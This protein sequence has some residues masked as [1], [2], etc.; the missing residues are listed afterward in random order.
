MARPA[1]KLANAL[2]A[3]ERLQTNGLVAIRSV[4]LSRLDRERLVEAGFLK[5]VMRGWYIPARPDEP[6]GESTAWFASFWEFVTAYLTERL[7]SDWILA[8]DQSLLL[9]SG[10]RTVPQQLLVRAPGGRNKPTELIHGTSLIDTRL[11][12]PA[13]RDRTVTADGVRIYRAEAAL[14]A[15]SPQF[16]LNYPTDAR[17]ALAAQRDA[18]ALLERLLDGGHSVVAGRLAGAFRNIGRNRIADD[19]SGT[20]KSAGYDV[21]ES[22]PFSHPLAYPLPRDPSP[23]A[24]RIRL[25][26]QDLREQLIGLFP[27]PAHRNDA[28]AY[29]AEVEENYVNDAYNSLSI[30]G[31]RVS[32][33]LIE[34]VRGGNWD[35]EFNEDDRAHRDAMAARGYWQS[36]QAVKSSLTEIL[37]GRNAGDVADRDHPV[38]YRE[39]FAPSVAAGIIKPSDLAG[40]RSN[41]V[42]IRGSRHVPLGPDAVRDAM[43]VFFDLLRDEPDPAVRV[44]LGHF[45][46]VYIHPY[47]DGNGRIGRFLMN[48]MMASGGYPWTIIPVDRR[49]QYMTV[50]ETAST[51]GELRPFGEFIAGL[52]K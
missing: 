10:N 25:M 48:A 29:L 31:Y 23:A 52:I 20:M 30:E 16:Y 6:A 46:F 33:G 42:F 28:A 24:N 19:I 21:R 26:W 14:V 1:E 22:D 34:R 40:Y 36:F 41:A 18:S 51:S 39:L 3:L 50:L 11:S 2:E 27:E 15:A 4:D 7:G 12:L 5:E 45:V 17:T 32:P 47:I 9:H 43:P 35:P 13:D 49:D 8:P 37:A 38:W 44:V